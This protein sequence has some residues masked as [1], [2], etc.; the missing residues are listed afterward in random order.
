[1]GWEIEKIGE[2]ERGFLDAKR[3]EY[4]TVVFVTSIPFA[5][6]QTDCLS[7]HGVDLIKDFSF[8][9]GYAVIVG[10]NGEGIKSA[11]EECDWVV[12]VQIPAM[13]IVD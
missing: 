3:E 9:D 13:A 5:K 6:I 12:Q 2:E 11:A 7:R 8:L 10:G 1:M 4:T